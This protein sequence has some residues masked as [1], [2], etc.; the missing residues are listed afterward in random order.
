VKRPHPKK[1]LTE[2]EIGDT[3]RLRIISGSLRT[4]IIEFS[5]DPRTRPMKDRTREAVFSLMGGKFSGYVAFDLFAGTGILAIECVSRGAAYGVAI[6]MLPRA[7]KEI[8]VNAK[9]LGVEDRF[10]IFTADTFTWIDDLNDHIQQLSRRFQTSIDAP[11]CVFICPPY[12][13][14]ESKTEALRDLLV[15]WVDAAPANSLFAIELDMSTPLSILPE[16]LE[17]QTR[18]YRPAMMA[19]GEK[20]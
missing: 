14:W 20:S 7:A 15:R 9:R 12:S 5:T 3:G 1:K 18:A 13:L 17:W 10:C 4:R 16:S 6:E 2:S 11:W 19:I 8:T